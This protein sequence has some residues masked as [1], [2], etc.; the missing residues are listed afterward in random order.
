MSASQPRARVDLPGGDSFLPEWVKDAVRALLSPIVRVAQALHITANTITVIG[1]AVVGV[2]AFLIGQGS[3][4]AGTAVLIAGSLLDTVDGALARA[5]G[6]TTPFGNFLDSTLDRAAEAFLFIGV[7]VYFIGQSDNPVG[8]VLAAL[9]ALT[10]SFLVSY[11]RAKAESLGYTASVGVAPRPERITLLSAGLLATGL[12][13][14]V[15][16][17]EA[18]WLI[19]GLTVA[20]IV[21][22]IWH[23]WRQAARPADRVVPP[24]TPKENHHRG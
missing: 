16:L 24:L 13:L 9:V 22:R 7:A 21:Q 12:G 1:L 5:T 15:G 10:G 17:L 20:T 23:V 6:G 14:P 18:V 11:T 3:L 19:A 8:P 4:V 2:A